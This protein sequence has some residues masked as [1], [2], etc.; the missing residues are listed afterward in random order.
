MKNKKTLL[1]FLLIMPLCMQAM[2]SSR[3]PAKNT[4]QKSSAN[5]GAKA[6]YK[7][8]AE[9]AM[10]SAKEAIIRAERAIA[11]SSVGRA[12]S[13]AK[14]AVGE[15]YTAAKT[16]LGFEVKATKPV[17]SQAEKAR[18]F[19][20]AYA[21]MKS[22]VGPVTLKTRPITLQDQAN[23][24]SLN[25]NQITKPIKPPKNQSPLA[26]QQSSQVASTG[27]ISLAPAKAPK[28]QSSLVAPPVPSSPAPTTRPGLTKAANLFVEP[29]VQTA[30]PVPS[31]APPALPTA[32]PVPSFAPPALPTAPAPRPVS[33]APVSGPVTAKVIGAPAQLLPSVAVAKSAPPAPRPSLP[34]SLSDQITS[35]RAALR[36]VSVPP[37]PAVV[38]SPPSSR[39]AF[40]P[41]PP[42][43]AQ[44]AAR[45]SLPSSLSEQINSR[46]QT[47]PLGSGPA[48]VL[49]SVPTSPAPS[50]PISVTQR[51]SSPAPRP[52]SP[53]ALSLAK[54]KLDTSSVRK[55][56]EVFKAET[57]AEKQNRALRETLESNRSK[58]APEEG[59]RRPESMVLSEPS[60]VINTPKSKLDLQREAKAAEAKAKAAKAKAEAETPEGKAKAK[61]E[62]VKAA[63]AAAKTA[64]SMAKQLKAKN[65]AAAKAKAEA[66]AAAIEDGW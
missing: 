42:P 38:A 9:K 8:Q 26:A 41:P 1:G 4:Q 12:A 46:G 29:V 57:P 20:N 3:G 63:E 59:P 24:P 49:N 50:S 51:P 40:Q 7:V 35:Q 34:S 11:E 28:A 2:K 33:A 6:S 39:P 43:P 60:K 47:A 19:E 44:A 58:I 32:P 55:V 54:S 52:F 61:V 23:N 36:S 56:K 14:V 16:K 65:D 10:T 13:R 18:E 17:K 64:E 30:P 15:A 25:A 45:P 21:E 53:E 5:S 22:S 48:P 62:A 27:S 66:D 31:F 37:A